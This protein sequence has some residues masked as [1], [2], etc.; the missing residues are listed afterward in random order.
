M[1]PYAPPE[2]DVDASDA[3]VGRTRKGSRSLYASETRSVALLVLFT[4]LSCGLYPAIW[5]VRR[6]RFLDELDSDAKLGVGLAWGGVIATAI[7]FVIALIVP[8]NT[9][10]QG[11]SAMTGIISL[12]QAFRV[13]HILRS[14]FA[15]TGRL[16]EVSGVPTFF[17]GVLYLQY[18]INRAAVTPGRKKKKKKKKKE[19]ETAP[20]AEA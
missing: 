2:A 10:A 5:Y 19:S 4:F 17:F 20:T 7:S 12:V 15:R 3:S 16:I 9:P 18:V 14:N 1:N 11:L 6:Q 8:P 13:A